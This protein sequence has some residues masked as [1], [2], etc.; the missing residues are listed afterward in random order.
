[1]RLVDRVAQCR[2][3]FIAICRSTGLQTRLAGAMDFADDA[4]KCP[5]RYVLS[6][7]LT[8][9]C[10]ALAYSKGAQSL[11]CTDL[12]RIPAERLWVEWAYAPWRNEL[13]RYGFPPSN[14]Q[15]D[16]CGRRGA[17]LMAS[18]DGRRGH[19]KTFW[20]TGEADIDVSVSP[21]Y[22]DFD[23]DAPERDNHQTAQ[24]HALRVM[25]G[26]SDSDSTIKTCFSFN[27][28]P[29]WAEY[30]DRAQLSAAHRQVLE[31]HSL[32]TVA[33][34]IPV[35]LAFFLLLNTRAGL[36]QQKSRLERLNKSRIRGGKAPLLD[37]IDVLAPFPSGYLSTRGDSESSGRRR[38]R[39]H[40]VRG[41]LVRRRN[42]LFWRVP[43]LR[44][45]SSAGVLKTR[46]VTWAFDQPQGRTTRQPTGPTTEPISA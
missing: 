41:H 43:H 22:A 34:D 16:N 24:S 29:T 13:D 38:P 28:E 23:F 3:P 15:F 33:L 40:H 11:A 12:V 35:I 1:M 46:T 2:T 7:E 25:N 31:H 26:P 20:C 45:N 14:D 9:L 37:H 32:G 8:R 6:D 4:A 10:A 18:R 17:L 21:M 19:V 44:G 42:E 27:F 36:P 5:I 30:Y 39:L